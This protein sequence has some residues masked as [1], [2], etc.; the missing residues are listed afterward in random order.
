MMVR[1]RTW[2]RRRRPVPLDA[3]GRSRYSPRRRSKRRACPTDATPTRG[4]VAAL[5]CATRL[6]ADKGKRPPSSA[7]VSPQMRFDLDFLVSWTCVAQRRLI[8]PQRRHLP[9]EGVSS[10]H[11]D[12]AEYPS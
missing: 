3:H 12:S 7:T 6:Q 9:P 5:P 1:S 4:G 2:M 10:R 8:H 11:W